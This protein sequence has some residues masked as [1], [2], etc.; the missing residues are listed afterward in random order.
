MS[1]FFTDRELETELLRQEEEEPLSDNESEDDEDYVEESEH[2][3]ES[4]L[5]TSS[6]DEEVNDASTSNNFYF[7]K[8]KN[9]KWNKKPIKVSGRTRQHNIITHLPGVKGIAKNAKT[10]HDTFKLYFDEELMN[11]LVLNTNIYI[12]KIRVNYKRVAD[13]QDTDIIELTAFIGLLLMSGVYRAAHLNIEELWDEDGPSIFSLTMSYKLFLFLYLCIRFDNINSRDERKK[14]VKLAAVREIIDLFEK[15]F[16]L[17]YTPAEYTT[18]D[19][20]LIPFRGRCPF[21]QYLP[22]KP[23]RYGIKVFTLVDS[24]TFYLLKFEIYAGAQHDGPYKKVNTPFD[25]VQ[26]LV[27]QIKGSGRNLT[28]DNWYSSGVDTCDQLCS[29]YNVGRRTR[30]WPLA[31]F[32]YF[33]NVSAVNAYIV[34]KSNTKETIKRRIFLKNLAKSLTLDHILRRGNN[35]H[36]LRSL[37]QKIWI[38]LGTQGI[39][40]EQVTNEVDNTRDS[41]K[42]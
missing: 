21:R 6:D 18:I 8:D 29:N 39:N 3:T 7:S 31:I 26:R 33:I 23:K 11:I 38:Y 12:L 37:R 22:N 15:K 24:R 35:N 36:I 32:N 10:P 2:D 17:A 20:Q 1:K 14:T 13:A 28:T 19:E 9:T 41:K 16:E 42:T 34:F 30:R 25:I 4:D 27:E 5:G 40:K